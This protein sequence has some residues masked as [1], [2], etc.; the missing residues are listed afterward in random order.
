MTARRVL[1]ALVQLGYMTEIAV[2]KVTRGYI[3]S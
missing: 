1:S 2:N 3:K